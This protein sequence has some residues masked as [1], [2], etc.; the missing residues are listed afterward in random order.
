[1]EEEQRVTL[2]VMCLSEPSPLLGSPCF[3]LRGSLESKKKKVEREKE[4]RREKRETYL[5]QTKENE[6][7]KRRGR[8][9]TNKLCLGMI[10]IQRVMNNFEF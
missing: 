10:C 5:K 2:S 1:M 9:I 6:D 4:E 8:K 7:S 3:T